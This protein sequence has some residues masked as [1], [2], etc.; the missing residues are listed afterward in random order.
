MRSRDG[1]GLLRCRYDRSRR[2]RNTGRSLAKVEWR[3]PLL[4]VYNA[5]SS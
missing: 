3:I 2:R 5:V 4:S 1:I